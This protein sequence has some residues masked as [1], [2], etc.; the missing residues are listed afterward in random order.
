MT[1]MACHKIHI[2]AE[3][4]VTCK[5]PIFDPDSQPPEQVTD[6]FTDMMPSYHNLVKSVSESEDP[7]LDV[8]RSK[9]TREDSS[10]PSQREKIL[11]SDKMKEYTMT[12]TRSSPRPIDAA[13]KSIATGEQN[14]GVKTCLI[15]FDEA[16]KGDVSKLYNETEDDNVSSKRATEMTIMMHNTETLKS[17]YL[18]RASVNTDDEKEEPP[19][20]HDDQDQAKLFKDMTKTS[21]RTPI[22][23]APARRKPTTPPTTR[24]A[25]PR[26]PMPSCPRIDVEKVAKV[27]AEVR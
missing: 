11:I 22:N 10:M 4:E 23:Q 26:E 6:D 13:Y 7:P 25:Q 18:L 24:R 16:H 1:T 8:S 20:N 9:G 2:F 14:H 17:A 19:G 12:A 15:M 5:A 3:D 21:L 27:P